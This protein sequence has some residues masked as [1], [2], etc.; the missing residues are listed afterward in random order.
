VG[1]KPAERRALARTFVAKAVYNF[2]HTR[3]SL[4]AL[5][6]SPMFRRIC[7]FTSLSEVPSESTFS[8]ALA[9]FAQQGLGEMVHQALVDYLYDVMDAAYDAGLIYQMS[10]TL[11][12]VPIIDKNSR[13]HEVIPLAPHEAARYRERTVVERGYSRLKENFGA[14]NLMVRGAQKVLLHLMFGVIALFADQLLKLIA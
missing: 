10:R 3:A 8:R 4:E 1:R 7:G 5:R 14:D 9:A 13:G 6:G 12:H 11:G 2:P